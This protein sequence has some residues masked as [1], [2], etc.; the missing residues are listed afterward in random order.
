MIQGLE[1][2]TSSLRIT[3]VMKATPPTFGIGRLHDFEYRLRSR[4]E[5]AG[6]IRR[7]AGWLFEECGAA[8]TPSLIEGRTPSPTRKA[9]ASAV[10]GNHLHGHAGFGGLSATLSGKRFSLSQNR[11]NQVG[12][13]VGRYIPAMDTM[14]SSPIPVS[15]L[16]LGRGGHSAGF[17][18][19]E[20]HE[21]QIP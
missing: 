5:T 3:L 13:V 4:A 19:V 8:H 15:M 2:R 14:R 20:L 18:P 11:K 17:I 9:A 16:G 6:S 10:I 1:N 21:H 7:P 12:I